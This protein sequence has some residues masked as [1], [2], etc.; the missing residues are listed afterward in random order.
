[1]EVNLGLDLGSVIRTTEP[2]VQNLEKK[3]KKIIS[4]ITGDEDS[5]NGI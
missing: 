4:K 2:M 3:F 1:M 5:Y